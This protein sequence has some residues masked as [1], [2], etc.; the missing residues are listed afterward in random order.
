MTRPGIEPWSP[1]L[2][3]NTL[4]I[5]PMSGDNHFTYNTVH[6]VR[7]CRG[8]LPSIYIKTRPNILSIKKNSE[9]SKY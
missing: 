2:L 3:A 1:G 6:S 9:C 5:M 7:K 8:T 4:T